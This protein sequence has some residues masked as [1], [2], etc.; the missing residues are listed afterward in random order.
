VVRKSALKTR[1][2]TVFVIDTSYL[3]EFFKLPGSEE[4]A[5]IEI[6]KRITN[7]VLD[8]NTLLYVTLPCLFELGNHIADVRDENRRQKLAHAFSNTIKTCLEKENPWTIIP[9][10]AIK[11]LFGLLDNFTHK[12]VIQCQKDKC[13][14]LV[15]TS[16]VDEAMRLKDKYKSFGYKVHIWTKDERLKAQEPDPENNPFLG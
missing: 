4:K 9:C 10:V 2:K 12:S 3:F 7:A 15:D 5:I 8:N 14:G 11:E 1:N 13:I 6:R 16:I